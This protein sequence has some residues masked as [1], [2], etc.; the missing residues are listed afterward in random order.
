MGTIVDSFLFLFIHYYG[1]RKLELF[2]LFLIG[3]MTITFG[4][5]MFYSGPSYSE[6]GEGVLIPS[7]PK[8]AWPSCIGIIGAVIMPHNLYLHSS[9]V[10]SR[11]V[12]YKNRSAINDANIYNALESAMSLGVSFLISTT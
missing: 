5:N 9:L 3:T 12:N 6:M 1:I 10:Q 4:T 8:G 2:F 7:V 11:K